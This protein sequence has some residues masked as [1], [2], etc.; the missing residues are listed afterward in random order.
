MT[1]RVQFPDGAVGRKSVRVPDVYFNS[2][3]SF[4]TPDTGYTKGTGGDGQIICVCIVSWDL[5][6]IKS[7]WKPSPSW[8]SRSITHTPAFTAHMHTQVEGGHNRKICTP[9]LKNSRGYEAFS[10][11]EGRPGLPGDKH[12]NTDVG[13]W[14]RSIQPTNLSSLAWYPTGSSSDSVFG[15]LRRQPSVWTISTGWDFYPVV[16]LF[17]ASR[18]NTVFT[19]KIL[20]RQAVLMFGRHSGI[21]PRS[22]EKVNNGVE[23]AG[24]RFRSGYIPRSGYNTPIGV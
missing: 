6:H 21:V 15:D 1:T 3:L 4:P 17:P 8:T 7:W 11:K 18:E 13:Q 19:V 14:V 10:L 9:L 5:R 16:D 23:Q 2:H 24:E 20:S 22:R 12:S